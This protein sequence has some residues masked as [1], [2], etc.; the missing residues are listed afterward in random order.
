VRQQRLEPLKI[1]D[2]NPAVMHV[3]HK[4]IDNAISPTVVVKYVQ[5]KIIFHLSHQ[6][7]SF[8]IH[9]RT[10]LLQRLSSSA[11]GSVGMHKTANKNQGGF[12]YYPPQTIF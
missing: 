1:S 8:T 2:H 5:L 4:Y 7:L 11:P 10:S 3:L 9:T 6:K 12:E